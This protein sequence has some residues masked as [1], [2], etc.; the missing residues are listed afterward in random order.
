MISSHGELVTFECHVS[1]TLWNWRARHVPSLWF[2][3]EEWVGLQLGCASPLSITMPQWVCSFSS[4]RARS[5]PVRSRDSDR[6]VGPSLSG[7]MKKN[8]LKSLFTSAVSLVIAVGCVIVGIFD[9][10][11]ETAELIG[12][13]AMRICGV[14]L[15]I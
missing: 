12:S 11:H 15:K 9:G 14:D 7:P 1:A 4:G 8:G 6:S 3:T 10:P 5:D 13:S 2:L